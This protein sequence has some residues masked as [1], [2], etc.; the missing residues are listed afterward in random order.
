MVHSHLQPHC[1][2]HFKEAIEGCTVPTVVMT[3][4]AWEESA[5]DQRIART[6]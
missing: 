6:A 5:H 2:D 4:E 1:E 3:T